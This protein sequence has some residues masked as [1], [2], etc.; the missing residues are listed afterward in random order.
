MIYLD[1]AAT[2]VMAKEVVEAMR[3]YWSELYGNPSSL[4]DFA[5]RSKNS[6]ENSRKQIAE[7]I[8]ARPEEIY[9]TSGGTESDNWA[10]N[11]AANAFSVKGRHIITSAIEHPA[12]INTCKSLNKNGFVITYIPVDEN[13]IVN[14]DELNKAITKETVLISVMYANNEIGTIQPVNEIAEIASKNGIAFHT[15]AVQAFCQIPINVK[16]SKIDMLSLSGHKFN[17]PKGVGALYIRQGLPVVPFMNGGSQERKKRA[18]T[19]NVPAIV[20]MAKAAEISAS[21]LN[22]KINREIKLRDYFMEN[23][24]QQNR[25]VRINGDI[26]NRLPGN[27]NVS[28]KDV[29][30]ESLLVMLDENGICASAGSA[31]SSMQNGN[32]HVLEAI[33]VPEEYIGGSVRFTL[34]EKNTKEEIAFVLHVIKEAVTKLRVN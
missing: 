15:D 16:K 3:P 12:I 4:Y 24:L 28:F 2:T 18:G 23:L 11:S 34:S 33:K 17:G 5:V 10:L 8:N 25:D 14:I 29:D 30:G 19:T 32:S 26:K 22:D 9:F 6:V 7:V 1:N 27:V 13:G 21:I 20:G 31:C